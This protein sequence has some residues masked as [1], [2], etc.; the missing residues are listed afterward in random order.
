MLQTHRLS[1]LPA[2][3]LRARLVKPR[4]HDS[5]THD[6]VLIADA[7]A[8]LY[9]ETHAISPGETRLVSISLFCALALEMLNGQIELQ[10]VAVDQLSHEY[11]TPSIT[12]PVLDPL[13]ERESEGLR[14]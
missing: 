9:S 12:L 13:M 3:L 2:R 10:I 14:S 6:I 8:D 7:T 5:P 11:V 4:M 1:G